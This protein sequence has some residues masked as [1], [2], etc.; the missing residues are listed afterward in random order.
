M[1]TEAKYLSMIT[2]QDLSGTPKSSL[3]CQCFITYGNIGSSEDT[4][5]KMFLRMSI[6]KYQVNG[7][8]KT[9]S[10]IFLK[11]FKS[12]LSHFL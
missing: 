9:K 3:L 2:T 7:D 8:Q 12:I 1:K 10:S 6:G 11:A 4:I 5:S